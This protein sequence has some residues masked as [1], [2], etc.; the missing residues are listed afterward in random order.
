M[1]SFISDQRSGFCLIMMILDFFD[2]S[3]QPK[4]EILSCVTVILL[5]ENNSIHSLSNNNDN[6]RT[7]IYE[8][9]QQ[10]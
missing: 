7:K 3:S 8:S 5:G 1:I 4:I 10:K 2:L 6:L 9:N